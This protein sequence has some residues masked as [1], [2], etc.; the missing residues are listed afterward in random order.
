[1]E[2]LNAKKGGG[3]KTGKGAGWKNLGRREAINFVRE[4]KDK[5]ERR[6]EKTAKGS[7]GGRKPN[8]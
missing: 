6:S 5:G 4:K 8:F 7:S 2:P 3:K 1:L